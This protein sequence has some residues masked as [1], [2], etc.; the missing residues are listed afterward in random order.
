M[1]E[2]I[3]L[4][5]DQARLIR[6]RGCSLEHQAL[7]QQAVEG[8]A[9]VDADDRGERGIDDGVDERADERRQEAAGMDAGTRFAAARKTSTWST[10][11]DDPGEDQ[12][13]RHDDGEHDRPDQRVEQGH[14][15]DDDHAIEEPVDG[16][17][18]QDPGRERERD[19]RDK[20]GDDQAP[21]G[22][23]PGLRAI[24]TALAAVSCT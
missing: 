12:R 13:S 20:Q 8:I 5:D 18:G 4:D 7:E 2:P 15:D 14:D 11:H 1:G 23:P 24:P 17:A 19:R 22:A 16:D 21:A 10:Q 6:V 3:D 9:A